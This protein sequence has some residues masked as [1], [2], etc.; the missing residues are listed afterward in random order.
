MPDIPPCVYDYSVRQVNRDTDSLEKELLDLG[1][2]GWE[3]VSILER[4]LTDSKTG[5]IIVSKKLIR[6]LE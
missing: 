1:D 2:K 5:W 4:G 3:V 6:T